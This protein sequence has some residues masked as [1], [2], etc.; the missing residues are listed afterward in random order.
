MFVKN[1]EASV[2]I[3]HH[4]SAKKM[5]ALLVATALPETFSSEE[6][7]CAMTH[8]ILQMQMCSVKK[9]DFSGQLRLQRIQG[10]W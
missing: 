7:Q 8:G 2:I 5:F 1:L 10:G 3:Y 9:L 6:R 4:V